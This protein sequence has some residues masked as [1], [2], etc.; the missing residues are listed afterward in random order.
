MWASSFAAV[1]AAFCQINGQF[2]PRESPDKRSN[3]HVQDSESRWEGKLQMGTK[4]NVLGD[5]CEDDSYKCC[6]GSLS[7]ETKGSAF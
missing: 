4:N 6:D 2:M 3:S 1:T 7:S 5:Q